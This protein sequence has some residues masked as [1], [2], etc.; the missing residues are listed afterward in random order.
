MK[1]F[2]L[3]S[4]LISFSL[5]SFGQRDS[6]SNS[7]FRSDI[8]LVSE[9]DTV[10]FK[11]SDVLKVSTNT[12]KY[13][14]SIDA[15]SKDSIM[16]DGINILINDIETL[17]VSKKATRTVGYIIAGIGAVSIGIG[18]AALGANDYG[19]FFG[20]LALI[21]GGVI[22]TPVGLIIVATSNRKYKLKEDWKLIV[23]SDDELNKP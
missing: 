6:L 15:V 20:G 7:K 21:A 13:I 5:L 8:Y 18:G 19:A 22:L 10:Y 11:K 3:F 2:V 12:H 14:G 4:M 16:I 23:V 1:D 9:T 17:R